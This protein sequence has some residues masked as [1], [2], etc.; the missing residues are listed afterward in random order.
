MTLIAAPMTED[1]VTM[2]TRQAVGTP[3]AGEWRC[4]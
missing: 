3:A 1:R 2:R 4:T